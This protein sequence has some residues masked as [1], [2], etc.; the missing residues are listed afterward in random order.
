MTMLPDGLITG[1]PAAPTASQNG[2]QGN[3]V[4]QKFMGAMQAIK[5]SGVEGGSMPPPMMNVPPPA[6]GLP[7]A[8]PALPRPAETVSD[9]MPR[10]TFDDG[11]VV[12]SIGDALRPIGDAI[13]SS[14]DYIRPTDGAFS[15][16]EYGNTGPLT[17][18]QRFASF[19]LNTAGGANPNFSGAAAW[20]NGQQKQRLDE[21]AAERA[22]GQLMGKFRGAP[23]F[24]AQ[25]AVG[26]INGTPT[27]TARQV[28]VQEAQSPA[29]IRQMNAAAAQAEVGADKPYNLKMQAISGLMKT[30]G[31]INDMEMNRGYDIKDPA[32]NAML[33]QQAR[34]NAQQA[35][36]QAT[37]MATETPRSGAAPI[38]TQPPAPTAPPGFRPAPDGKYYAPDPQRPGKY[39]MWTP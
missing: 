32:R 13:K 14:I 26:N 27:V 20:Y 39:L 12:Q 28:G 3:P 17:D 23:T 15:R 36:N 6:Q 31:E 9:V 4:L 22:A 25:T 19:L 7:S 37:S 30:I 16:D 1:A 2:T 38:Q 5:N 33:A 11:G 29:H 24:D 18:R 8:F 10:Q 35:F 21:M 34:Q